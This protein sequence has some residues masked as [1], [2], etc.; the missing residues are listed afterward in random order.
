[1][2]LLDN[3]KKNRA[4]RISALQNATTVQNFDDGSY[5]PERDSEGNASVVL[6]FLPQ[7]DVDAIPFVTY[8]THKFKGDDG[9]WLFVDLCPT[10]IGNKCPICEKNSI[11][12]Q[13]GTPENQNIARARK[14]KKEYVANVLVVKDPKSPE[15]EGK[16]F[17][18]K[19]GAS[20][21][22]KIKSAINPKYEDEKALNPFDL[23]EGANFLLRIR[24]DPVKKQTTYEDSKFDTQ[25]ALFDGDEAKLEKVLEECKDLSTF[26]DPSKIM[27]EAEL[28]R[29]TENAYMNCG[30]NSHKQNM[31]FT[32]E[33]VK[34]ETPMPEFPSQNVAPSE[35][36]NTNE[37]TDDDPL[38]SFRQMVDEIPF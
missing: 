18:F 25:S 7:K 4:G 27:A 23:W 20:I 16:V 12:W 32:P 26:K 19:F 29:R 8:Y 22:E 24:K 34:N 13:T 36:I 33:P 6:R 17:I 37:T 11:L 35:S 30:I 3:F 9:K 31:S 28:Y 15:K 38:A 1:M 2:G 21:Y 14:R 5:F 10:T